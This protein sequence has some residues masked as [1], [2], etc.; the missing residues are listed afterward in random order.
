MSERDSFEEIIARVL[1]GDAPLNV[2]AAAARG[3]LP[4]ARAELLRLQ[5]LLLGDASPDI[6]AAAESSLGQAESSVVGDA[7][8]DPDC[9]PD[10]L[11]YFSKRGARD[12]K[13]A[14]KIVFHRAVPV[15][16]LGQ[17]AAT[18]S[19]PVIDLVLTNQELLLSRPAMLEK[20]MVNPALRPDQR[21]RILEL[22]ERVARRPA[23]ETTTESDDGS[24]DEEMSIDEAARLLDVDVGELMSAS[25]ILGGE[26]FERSEDVELRSTYSKIL[27][28]NPAQKA[29]LAMKG[30]REERMILVRDSNRTVA[31]GVLKNGRIT[32]GEIEGFAKMRNVVEDVLRHIAINREWTKNYSV[33]QALI[34]NPRTPPSVSTNF[35]SRLTNRDL[36]SLGASRDVPELIRRMA[37]R[38]LD[39]RTQRDRIVLKPK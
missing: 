30:G 31:L 36:K 12:E 22:L 23:T 37:R 15:E 32:D 27:T 9:A 14:E 38:V 39:T 35:V 7:L 8:A 19:A 26:E 11:K 10:V 3:A 29:L 1:E 20:L 2:R 28:L 25:E 18:G 5:V 34:K 6:A 17:L 13:L 33:I 4:L 21:G 24:D 16:A